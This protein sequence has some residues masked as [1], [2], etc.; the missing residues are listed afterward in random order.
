MRLAK[1]TSNLFRHRTSPGGLSI[2]VR[3]LNRVMSIDPDKL[4]A[5][6]EGMTTYA[7]VVRATL[8]YNLLPCVTPELKTITVG[9]AIS[10]L[11]I[12]SSSFRFGLAHESVQEMEVVTGDGNVVKCSREMNP[13]LFYALPNSY[14]TLGYIVRATIRLMHVLAYVEVEHASYC[15][16]GEF[17]R[18]L[19]AAIADGAVDFVD[20]MVLDGRNLYLT[21]G[22]MRTDAPWASNYRS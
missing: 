20:G 3:N 4:L 21:T 5:T 8:A 6:V 15:N 11:G 2:D 12:E 19:E 1:D 14:G 22:K 18:V 7:D 16:S 9:G 17:F 10:G 13:D